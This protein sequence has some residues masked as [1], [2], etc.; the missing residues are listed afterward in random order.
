MSPCR[1]TI[2]LNTHGICSG[3]RS[4][5]TLTPCSRARLASGSLSGVAL[6]SPDFTASRRRMP[7][8]YSF[9]TTFLQHH[10]VAREREP[11]QRE[12]N[13]GIALGAERAHADHA[14]LELGRGLHPGGGE[15]G[16]ADH[17]AQGADGAD[18][19]AS[20]VDADHRGQTHVHDVEPAGLKLGRAA[21]AAAHVDD[22]DL[23]PLSGVETGIA[24]PVPRQH[25]VDGIGD[26]G[27]DLDRLLRRPR[28]PPDD[29]ESQDGGAD[30]RAPRTDFR[31][32]RDSFAIF[33][34]RS[35]DGGEVKTPGTA[36]RIPRCG[37]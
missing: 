30:A 32:H 25:G 5:R 33:L 24:G 4:T 1:T 35:A 15:E 31:W 29:D 16:E 3:T 12:R 36:G 10:V 8:P 14:A 2:E 22:V 6:I 28:P 7:P 26:A 18:I 19:A 27:F 9:N 20:A 17:V 23:E 11:R 13:G 34:S 21:A 37:R